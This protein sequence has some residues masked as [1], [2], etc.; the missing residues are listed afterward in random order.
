MTPH[1]QWPSRKR[2]VLRRASGLSKHGKV[3]TS[4]TL[5]GAAAFASQVGAGLLATGTRLRPIGA[6]GRFPSSKPRWHELAGVFPLAELAFSPYKYCQF[7]GT[8]L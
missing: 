7:A 5:P 1:S 2:A 3:D 4:A 8:N 6:N